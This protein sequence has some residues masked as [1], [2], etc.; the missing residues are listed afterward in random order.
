[1]PNRAHEPGRPRRG[2]R[3]PVGPHEPVFRQR[4]A[5]CRYKAADLRSVADQLERLGPNPTGLSRDRLDLARLGAFGHSFGGNAALEWCRADPRCRA[6]A[7]MDG[8]I[9]TEI[10]SMGLQRLALQL[11][12]QPP[13]SRCPARRPSRRA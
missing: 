11:L 10:G 8:A 12:A 13:S 3:A 7:N 5:V 2:P 4:A 1:M 6:A 9:W